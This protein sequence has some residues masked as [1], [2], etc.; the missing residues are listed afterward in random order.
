MRK[1]GAKW[2]T[3]RYVK[4]TGRFVG[5][6]TYTVKALFRGKSIKTGRYRLRLAAEGNSKTL[7]FRVT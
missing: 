7:A 2:L 6:R 1:K 4:K 3:V 5:K